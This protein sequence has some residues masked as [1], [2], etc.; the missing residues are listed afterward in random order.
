MK[1][2]SVGTHHN[3]YLMFEDMNVHIATFVRN[4]ERSIARRKETLIL[5]DKSSVKI[6]GVKS[7]CGDFFTIR[8]SSRV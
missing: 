8:F 4:K 1:R 2:I 6:M 7:E 5:C 3:S